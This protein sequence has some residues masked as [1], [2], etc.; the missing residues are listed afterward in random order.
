MAGFRVSIVVPAYHAEHAIGPLLDSLGR[1][2]YPEYEVI[3]VN[4]GSKDRTREIIEQYPVRLINQTN[5]GASAARDAGLRAASGEIV[6][7]VDSDVAVTPDWLKQIV[8]PFADPP[9]GA[10]TGRTVFLRNEKCASWMRS[11]DIE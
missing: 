7:Y 11:L 3:I 10:T 5:R 2:D 1:L 9:I 6:A 8:Q 4:D